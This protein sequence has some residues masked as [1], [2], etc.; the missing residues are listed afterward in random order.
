MAPNCNLEIFTEFSGVQRRDIEEGRWWKKRVETKDSMKDG[1]KDQI[2]DKAPPGR[3][4][5][6]SYRNFTVYSLR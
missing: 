3:G 1:T 6:G 2:S 5:G 4:G